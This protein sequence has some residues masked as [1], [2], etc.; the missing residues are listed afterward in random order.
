MRKK[1]LVLTAALGCALARNLTAAEAPSTCSAPA[2]DA[3]R[4]TTLVTP[5]AQYSAGA[6]HRFLLGREYRDLWTTPLQ[7]PVLDLESFASGLVP[8]EKGGGKQTLTLD[9]KGG[10]GREYKFRSVD[11]DPSGVLPR[12]LR[13]TFAD[14]V[15]QDQISSALPTGE[16]VLGPLL[17][18]AG[19]PH[20]EPRL[21]VLPD[22]PLLGE[23]RGE[24]A[25]MLGTL[26]EAPSA[27]APVSA[28][29]SGFSKVLNSEKLM[30]LL[31]ESAEHR[32]DE[33][34][35]LKARL[36]DILIGDWDRHQKQW[37]WAR[38][39]E[40]QLY[41]PVPKDRDQAFARFDGFLLSMARLGDPRLINFS[42]DY[43]GMR[44]L[45]WNSREL[46]RRVLSGLEKPQWDEVVAELREAITDEVIEAAMCRLP[47]EY[48]ATEARRLAAVLR[49]RRDGLPQAAAEFYD[50]LAREVDVFATDAD[51]LAL[52]ERQE[53][54]E[55]ELRLIA[56][57]EDGE[58]RSPP[59]F[60]RRFRP[61]ETHEV[62]V[63][64]R[65]GND[66]AVSRG[67]A[68]RRI[69]MRVMGGD[70]DDTLDDSKGGGSRFYDD[71]ESQVLAG[72]GT[73]RDLRPY[74]APG[75]P[76]DGR[77]LDWGRSTVPLP[78]VSFD[79]DLGL[80]VGG[81]VQLTDYG[82]RKHPYA[83]RHT[84][85]AGYS[86]GA[87]SYRADYKG[88][89][90]RPNSNARGLLELRASGLEVV[91]FYGFGNENAAPGPDDFY[92][93]EQQ[94]YSLAPSFVVD[95]AR[96]SLSV[97][98]VAKFATTRLS[99]GQFIS[100]AQP[101]GSDDFGQVGA[102]MTVGVDLRDQP[103]AP[104][105][106]L[107]LTAGA[108]VFPSVWSVKSTFGTVQAEAGSHLP[109]P[110]PLRPSLAV[111]VGAKRVFGV[112]PFH[113]AA[114]LGGSSTLRGLARNRYAGDSA[115]YSNAEL[116]VRVTRLGFLFSSELGVFA[117]GDVGRVYLEGEASDRWHT[118]VGGG[119]WL[120]FRQGKNI[121]SASVAR[122][123]G[124][125]GVYLHG[126]LLF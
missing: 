76:E 42:E 53:Q 13:G 73:S 91:R 62:R 59:Y 27:E 52:I 65:G 97:G 5:G 112:Y 23:F 117:L 98:P 21:V 70:G 32:I 101:Y 19:I 24:F 125:T 90:R 45:M 109:L 79:R 36:L 69:T 103:G 1:S 11:K 58:R 29:F 30:K 47:A 92:K 25:G 15:V 38:S 34:A 16:L 110:L 115:L 2:A 118:A 50:L 93:V 80:V 28:G 9:F 46:D 74:Q 35:F 54:G 63:Y 71:Q 85:R 89:F 56:I 81:G 39:R 41:E 44:G 55:I 64:L 12:V 18:A 84:V 75:D 82:F 68:E 83:S 106:G 33:R 104:R 124:R 114:F 102:E 37:N 3:G 48:R 17:A 111:R 61:S 99:P 94:Q 60:R 126:G 77:P 57:G 87:T 66:R 31:D 14:R 113:E 107:L 88:D 22:H 120:A 121:F 86:T 105:R 20:I 72:P 4:E 51:D 119:L 40:S 8:V 122:S 26:L 96:F 78:Y 95:A 123:E 67:E 10:D 100:L 49:A 43:P 6:L 108:S 116:R 7:V